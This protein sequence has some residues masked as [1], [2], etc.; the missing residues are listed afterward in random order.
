MGRSKAVGTIE[1]GPGALVE[2]GGWAQHRRY[3]SGAFGGV[4]VF[5]LDLEMDGKLPKGWI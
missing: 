3:W 2:E 1:R 4:W 5:G